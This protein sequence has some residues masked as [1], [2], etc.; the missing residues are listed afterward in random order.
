MNLRQPLQH[1]RIGKLG[2]YDF[3]SGYYLY[4]GSAFGPGGL[5]ARIKHHLQQQKPRLHWHIDYLRAY[6]DVLEVWRVASDVRLETAWSKTLAQ[7]FSIPVAGFG[8]SDTNSPS[9][10]FYSQQLIPIRIISQTLFECLVFS[11]TVL[12]PINISIEIFKPTP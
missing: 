7:N 8:A 3:A 5:N 9:H 6:A 12:F 10:L 11:D 4:V 2:C 1:Y